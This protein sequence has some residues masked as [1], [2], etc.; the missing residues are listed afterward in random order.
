MSRS[1]LVVGVSGIAGSALA[2]HLLAQGWTVSGLARTP[3]ALEGLRPVAADLRD[4][5]APLR[6]RRRATFFS[7]PGYARRPRPKISG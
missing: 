3:P 6:T 4:P 2:R 5:P 7:P 1:A